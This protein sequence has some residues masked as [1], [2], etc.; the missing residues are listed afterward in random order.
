MAIKTTAE[1][2]EAVQTAIEAVESGQ[3]Y[4]VGNMTYTRATL[5]TLYAREDKLL[6]RYN[7][8]QGN[9]PYGSHAT[10]RAAGYRTGGTTSERIC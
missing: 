5:S 7:R 8:E 6:T 4:K 10:F 3:S 1:Q 2:L 9:S